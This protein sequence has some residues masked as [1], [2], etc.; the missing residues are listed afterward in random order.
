MGGK[1]RRSG[2]R[3]GGGKLVSYKILFG[4]L[5]SKHVLLVHALFRNN[6]KVNKHEWLSP[7]KPLELISAALQAFS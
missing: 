5:I 3:Q 7:W 2:E 6:L 4:F 1:K